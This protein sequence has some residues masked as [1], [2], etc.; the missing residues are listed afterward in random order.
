MGIGAYNARHLRDCLDDTTILTKQ[1][2]VPALQKAR[3]KAGPIAQQALERLEQ[4][5]EATRQGAVQLLKCGGQ[6]ADSPRKLV[7]LASP[8][9]KSRCQP[10]KAISQPWSRMRP[11]EASTPKWKEGSKKAEEEQCREEERRRVEEAARKQA[12]DRLKKDAAEAWRQRKAEAEQLR[13]EERRFV[14]EAARKQAEDRQTGSPAR[15]KKEANRQRQ[16]EEEQRG[17]W[18]EWED[19]ARK[20]A[21]DEAVKKVVDRLQENSERGVCQTATPYLKS[22]PRRTA[23]LS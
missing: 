4:A 23:L 21:E 10:T 3:D 14:E 16:A 5:E 9:F 19:A 13:E 20:Q 11:N 18:M 17:M 15:L 7:E 6:A 2:A 8:Y 12:E 1:K 22:F